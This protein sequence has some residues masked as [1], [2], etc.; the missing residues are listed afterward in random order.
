MRRNGTWEQK[1]GDGRATVARLKLIG[2]KDKAR[3]NESLPW[4]NRYCFFFLS[5]EN[6]MKTME[7]LLMPSTTASIIYDTR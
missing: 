6:S 2:K 1:E 5:L 3:K 7:T 4:E